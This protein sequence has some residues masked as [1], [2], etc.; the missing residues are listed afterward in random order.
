MKEKITNYF[1]NLF[2]SKVSEYV[3][4]DGI[5]EVFTGAID[6]LDVLAG[7]MGDRSDDLS[8]QAAALITEANEAIA[9]ASKAQ[10]YAAKIRTLFDDE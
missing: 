7:K 9:E 3:T 10:K 8:E 5:I 4:A 2:V 1:K 6:K